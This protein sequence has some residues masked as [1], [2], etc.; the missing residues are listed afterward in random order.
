[1]P[2]YEFRCVQCGEVYEKLI[3]ESD[4]KIELKCPECGSDTADR[5]ISRANSIIGGSKGKRTTLTR[6]S[7]GP[8]SSCHT[9]EIPGAGD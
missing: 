5:V 3:R 9:L 2:I 8:G 1:M 6:K 4:E 7:C